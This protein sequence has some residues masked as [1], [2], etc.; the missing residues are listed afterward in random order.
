VTD[1]IGKLEIDGLA[2]L[3]IDLKDHGTLTVI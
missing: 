2:R 1:L 3:E